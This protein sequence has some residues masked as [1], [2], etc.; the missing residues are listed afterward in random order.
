MIRIK[1]CTICR[2][3]KKEYIKT[4]QILTG[5]EMFEEELLLIIETSELPAEI[6]PCTKDG[7][8]ITT[9]RGGFEY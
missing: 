4:I 8:E 7:L 5:R 9:Y 3:G 2:L 6:N 1:S